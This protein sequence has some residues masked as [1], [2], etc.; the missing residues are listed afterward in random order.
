MRNGK[1]CKVKHWINRLL[2]LGKTHTL[3]LART[4]M[5]T[6]SLIKHS[7]RGKL[8]RLVSGCVNDAKAQV[9]MSKSVYSNLETIFVHPADRVEV[10]QNSDLVKVHTWV[11]F[12]RLLVLNFSNQL[13]R[14]FINTATSKPTVPR[15]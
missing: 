6:N 13:T 4:H 8:L 9:E 12:S 11:S 1:H 2:M 5:Q 15:H 10:K 3:S 14:W 7:Q